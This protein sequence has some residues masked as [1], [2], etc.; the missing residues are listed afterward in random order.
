MGIVTACQ[1]GSQYVGLCGDVYGGVHTL[2]ED[3]NNDLPDVANA[4]TRPILFHVQSGHID[5]GTLRPKR[6]HEFRLRVARGNH[7]VKPADATIQF[8]DD[9]ET[10]WGPYNIDLGANNEN[11]IVYKFQSGGIFR[12]RQY[13]IQSNNEAEFHISGAEED[14]EVL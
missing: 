13:I 14:I 6:S 2:S 10:Y 7:I 8:C 1:A 12:T 4:L 3:S 5:Y 11:D 9:R